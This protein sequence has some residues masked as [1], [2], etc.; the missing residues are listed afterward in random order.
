[1]KYCLVL[2]TVFI[3]QLF[4][5]SVQANML[6]PELTYFTSS[7]LVAA[8]PPMVNT[9]RVDQTSL[10]IQCRNNCTIKAEYT[11]FSS[12]S[13]ETVLTFVLPGP[14]KLQ[15]SVN[16]T[17]VPVSATSTR[18]RTD[19]SFQQKDPFFQMQMSLFLLEQPYT[20]RPTPLFFASFKAPFSAGPNTI[21]V[22]YEQPYNRDIYSYRNGTI[23]QLRYELWPLR[24]WYLSNTF[25]MTISAEFSRTL[26]EEDELLVHYYDDQFADSS[27]IERFTSPSSTI[28][29]E[30]Q[31]KHTFPGRIVWF[32]GNKDI[33]GVSKG[34]I[35]NK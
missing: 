11:I 9:F 33:L 7:L 4:H 17:S 24:D 27:T 29:F 22:Q 28:I 15:A 1:M 19:L 23:Q 21:Q 16:G 25:T 32:V 10:K 2:F 31:W 34:F 30:K 13:A 12:Q 5:S 20:Q 8:D 18:G 6:P 3:A 26:P 14:A 35:Q